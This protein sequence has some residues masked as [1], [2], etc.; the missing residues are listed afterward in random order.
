MKS[1]R[2]SVLKALVAALEEGSGPDRASLFVRDFIISQLAQNDI[3]NLWAIEDPISALKK[4]CNNEGLSE[5]EPRLVG[6]AGRN[7]ILSCY[8]IGLYIDKQLIGLGE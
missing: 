3:N 2:A 1:T 7:T 4:I 8:R 6:E 5:P